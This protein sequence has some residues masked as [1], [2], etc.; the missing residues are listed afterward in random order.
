MLLRCFT[1]VRRLERLSFLQELGKDVDQNE[2]NIDLWEYT[3]FVRICWR[4]WEH[5]S[6]SEYMPYKRRFATCWK[7]H[8]DFTKY[9]SR[10]IDRSPPTRRVISIQKACDNP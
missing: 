6:M 9:L 3:I 8:I 5:Y 2:D 4:R 7:S 1:T 10:N